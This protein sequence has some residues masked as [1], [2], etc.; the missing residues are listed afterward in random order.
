MGSRAKVPAMKR[1]IARIVLE[2][3]VEIEAE[4]GVCEVLQDKSLCK[5][6]VMT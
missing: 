2:C 3:I 4:L 1:P 6:R 5:S